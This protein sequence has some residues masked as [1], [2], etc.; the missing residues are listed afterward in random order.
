MALGRLVQI[1]SE[2]QLLLLV[3][4][5]IVHFDHF[6]RGQIVNIILLYFVKLETSGHGHLI[7]LVSFEV[8]NKSLEF[9]PNVD[10]HSNYKLSISIT[11]QFLKMFKFLPQGTKTR[12]T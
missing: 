5:D 12:L 8:R 9:F 3:G 10:P 2:L 11:L 1:E 4:N 6:I 7:S